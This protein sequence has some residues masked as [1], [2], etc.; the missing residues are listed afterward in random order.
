MKSALILTVGTTAEPLRRALEEVSD[1]TRPIVV[2]LVYGRPLPG[3]HPDPFQVAMDITACAQAMELEVRPREISDPEDLDECL[4]VLRR[5][6]VEAAS[7]ERIIINLTGGTKPMAG[8]LVHAALSE[9]VSGNVEFH[10]VGGQLRDQNGRVIREAMSVRRSPRT[11]TQSRIEQVVT[12]LRGHRYELAA[13]TA[14]RLPDTG[15]PGFLKAAAQACL[16]WDEFQYERAEQILRL[17]NQQAKVLT[18]DYELGAL[19][20]TL[21]RLRRL[22]DHF[23]A[24]T[25]SLRSL[26]NKGPEEIGGERITYLCAD[27]LENAARRLASG[28]YIEAVLRS[29]RAVETAIQAQL[30]EAGINPWRPQWEALSSRAV[31]IISERLGKLP[32]ELALYTGLVALEAVSGQRLD[33]TQR[34]RLRDLQ[35]TRN[36]SMLEHGYEFCDEEDARRCLGIAQELTERLLDISLEPLRQEVRLKA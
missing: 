33:G 2:F 24:A 21:L 4:R 16:C 34:Q 10:Y 29:Y 32:N 3:Q 14:S 17:I 18:D 36:H 7:A 25:R 9:G 30:L 31:Q 23:V 28:A 5:V 27:V 22:A 1:L 20:E 13:E 35:R 8:A 11:A 15:R 6:V 19:A 26:Q 12:A